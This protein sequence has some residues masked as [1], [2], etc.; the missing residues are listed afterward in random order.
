MQGNGEDHHVGRGRQRQAER[1]ERDRQ[2][3]QHDGDDEQRPDIS[4]VIGLIR[5]S[6]CARR[7]GHA[8]KQQ[9]EPPSAGTSRL[10][11]GRLEIRRE[12]AH[13][14]DQ[15]GCPQ[16]PP[17]RPEPPITTT[18]EGRGENLGSI[19]DEYSRSGRAA[20][21]QGPRG[22]RRWR[23]AITVGSS[24]EMPSGSRPDSRSTFCHARAHP[25]GRVVR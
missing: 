12:A 3:E 4:A 1:K 2:H 22:Q 15:Q 20:R 19:A 17:E 25:R 23:D 5:T 9:H 11:R 16:P 13:D 24:S 18:N 21:R 10:A 6:G 7:T 14:T 8:A